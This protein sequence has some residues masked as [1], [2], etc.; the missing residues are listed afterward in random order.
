ML[1][2]QIYG[3]NNIRK[4]REGSEN[5]GEGT[6]YTTGVTQSKRREGSENGGEGTGY[7][8]GVTQSGW[9]AWRHYRCLGLGRGRGPSVLELF[10]HIQQH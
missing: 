6:G 5:G 4:R 3:S 10:R 7:T 1:W 2:S 9:L 8:T